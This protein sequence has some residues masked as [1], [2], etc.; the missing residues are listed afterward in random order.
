M[1]CASVLS[2]LQ[3][4]YGPANW[5]IG[6]EPVSELVFTILT[7]NTSDRNAERAFTKL[8]AHFPNMNQ[9]LHAGVDEIKSL[10]AEAG[11]SN[12]K[13]PRIK[14][15][16]ITIMERRGSLDLW[17]L[18]TMTPQHAKEWLMS[19]AGVGPKTASVVLCLSLGVPALPVDTHVLRVSKRLG[20]I[21][22]GIS[23]E[24]A[25]LILEALVRP[26]DMLEFHMQIIRHGR[27]ICHSRSPQCSVCPLAFNCTY[28]TDMSLKG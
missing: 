25:H 4:A 18:K 21:E 28:A 7:Q 17:F 2:V 3:E 5:R 8:T 11:L 10:I 27:T 19:I 23:A 9:L 16:L 13:A 22:P 20:L 1:E 12:I 6:Y 26:S 15:A 14:N 24:K